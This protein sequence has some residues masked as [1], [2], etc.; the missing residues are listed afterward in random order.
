MSKKIRVG[1]TLTLPPS[2][3]VVGTDHSVI[4]KEESYDHSR[5][6]PNREHQ[7]RSDKL[8]KESLS[9][10]GKLNKESHHLPSVSGKLNKESHHHPFMSRKPNK[11]SYDHPFV[12]GKLNKESLYL[13][14]NEAVDK[15]ACKGLYKDEKYAV[16]YQ[17]FKNR[18]HI[19]Q[20]YIPANFSNSFRNPCWY[21]FHQKPMLSSLKTTTTCATPS[22]YTPSIA[23]HTIQ[24]YENLL[25]S[26][27][28]LSCL[29]A[30]FLSGF[31]KC[32]STT[33]YAMIIQHSKIAAP[34]CKEC[35]FWSQFVNPRGTNLDKKIQVLRYFDIFTHTI[36]SIESNPRR[37]TLDAS[38]SYHIWNS[39]SDYCVIP[40]L[41]LRV[42]PES[43][44][45][46]IMRNPSTRVFSHY[47]FYTVERAFDNSLEYFEYATS[48]KALETFHIHVVNVIMKFQSCLDRGHSVSH[49]VRDKTIDRKDINRNGRVGLQTS[50]YYYHIV[51]WLNIFPRERFL[52]LRMEDLV[53]NQSFT[54]SR[55]WHFLDLDDLPTIQSKFQNVNKQ[56][57]NITFPPKTKEVLDTF[58]QPCNQ[59][60]ANLLSDRRYL[61]KD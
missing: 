43:K 37:I 21:H 22:S 47:W 2:Q 39:E 26:A 20:A 46:L 51:P 29:P 19:L 6:K 14:M 38:V 17:T 45:V 58:F 44:F 41:L 18:L 27:Q 28:R 8:N 9:V 54:M 49:C 56:T 32:A 3:T 11:K 16:Q 15:H 12:S 25:A 48:M 30:F 61:W 1:N 59:L 35:H 24:N 5:D 50:M 7:V 40:S 53:H 52:F 13:L 33:L 10:S 31:P 36:H 23:N 57:R 60:L 4:L 34:R 42:L 55:V